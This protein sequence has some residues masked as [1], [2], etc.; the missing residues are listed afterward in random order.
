V[1]RTL[2]LCSTLLVLSTLVCSS[3]Q[4]GDEP[5]SLKLKDRALEGLEERLIQ[6]PRNPGLL[7]DYATSL[8]KSGRIAEAQATYESSLAIAPNSLITLYN[9]A[10]LHLEL[11]H[12][13]V[14]GRHLRH[15]LDLDP[16][17]ARAHYAMGSFYVNKNKHRRAVEHFATAFTLDPQLRDPEHNPEILFN[18]LLSWA[19]MKSY[20]ETPLGR[21]TRVYHD[22]RPII[23]A[24][25]QEID[26]AN[27]GEPA[28]DDANGEDTG[29]Q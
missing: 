4:A 27:G 18:R 2:A 1:K 9:L 24:L 22:P 26:T 14:A 8:F 11:G 13:E 20:I 19:L 5:L 15:S 17:F 29:R 10:L 6:D 7:T 21:G 16:T 23:G 28:T 12:N 3:L 25:I